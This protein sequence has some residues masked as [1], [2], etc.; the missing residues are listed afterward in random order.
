ML[1]DDFIEKFKRLNIDYL[2]N[3]NPPTYPDGI[4]VEVFTKELIQTFL[5][6][7]LLKYLIENM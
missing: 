3:T 1:V 5:M 4:D 7:M 2:S 6:K